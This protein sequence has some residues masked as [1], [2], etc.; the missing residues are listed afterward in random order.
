MI[1]PVLLEAIQAGF[2]GVVETTINVSKVSI[3][4]RILD[5]SLF[6]LHD[7]SDL[8]DLFNRK[9]A[10]AAIDR[11]LGSGYHDR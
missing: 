6:D 10:L 3:L 11:W 2:R 8:S 4:N 1:I 7:A 5:G 9:T